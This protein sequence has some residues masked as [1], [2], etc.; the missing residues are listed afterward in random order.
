MAELVSLEQA[1]AQVRITWTDEDEHLQ[2]LLTAA[3]GVVT[4][5]V[6]QRISDADTWSE[7]VAAWTEDTVP[8]Q[9]R[10]AILLQ[11]AALSRF[12]GNDE[13]R[14]SG[15]DEHGLAVGVRGL[16]TRLRDPALSGASEEEEE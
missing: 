13:A 12:R 11:F 3:Q 4:E 15:F 16:L 5:F 7:T 14:V 9:V 10:L 1:K 6:D 8:E 2:L